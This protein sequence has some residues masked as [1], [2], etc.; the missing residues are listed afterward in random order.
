MRTLKL[1]S[2]GQVINNHQAIRV[3]RDT[4]GNADEFQVQF[5]L[6]SRR[7]HED[8]TYFTDDKDDALD[9]AQYEFN[10]YMEVLLPR[11]EK[12]RQLENAGVK[13]ERSIKGTVGQ[14]INLSES[15]SP[16]TK[17]LKKILKKK[18]AS[19]KRHK[20]EVNY[21]N[22]MGSY[23]TPTGYNDQHVAV[24]CSKC[25]KT[26]WRNGRTGRMLNR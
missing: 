20:W 15:N 24:K 11:E 12:E 10:R 17:R 6:P 9:T 19:C 14:P 4:T 22:S 26:G 21:N 2:F 23:M 13:T 25:N 1:M 5:L 18:A 7:V 8:A 16:A 3:Q